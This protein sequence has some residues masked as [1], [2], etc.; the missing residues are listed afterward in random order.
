MKVNLN[1]QKLQQGKRDLSIEPRFLV[2]TVMTNGAF[3]PMSK[4]SEGGILLR[5]S[6]TDREDS[7][8]N[9]I[10]EFLLKAEQCDK[11]SRAREKEV[12]GV[13]FY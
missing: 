5:R 6:I 3:W 2:N 7:G 12:K 4:G 8:C 10:G 11:M 1:Q 9:D 13:S